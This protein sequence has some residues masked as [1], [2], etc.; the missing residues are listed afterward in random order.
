MAS[1]PDL[2]AE[3]AHIDRAYDSLERSRIEATRAALDGRGRQGRH[4]AGPLGAG[5]DRG[6]HR[7]A[8]GL[9]PAGRRQPGVRAH[10]PHPERGRATAS[11]SGAWP[12]PTSTASRWSSTGGPPWPSPSTG[13][14][15]ARRWAWSAAAT[16]PPGAAS[17]WPSRTSCSASRPGCSAASWP[18][19]D[20]GREIRGKSTLITA[21]EEVRTGPPHRHRR[22]DPGRA[23]RDH[24]GRP[25]RRAGRAGRPGHRQDGRGAAPRRLPALHAPLP[26]RGPGRAGGRARTGCSSATS[27]RCC[28]A[29][30]RPAWSWS[31]LADLLDGA[32]TL[33][34][35]GRDDQVAGPRQGRP[36]HGPRAGQ[37]RARPPAAACGPRCGSASACRPS[38]SARA[39]ATPS[40]PTPAAASASTTPAGAT[41]RPASTPP[42]PTAPAI[43]VEEHE[44]RGRLHATRRAARGPRPHVA[45]PHAGRAAP[46][47]VRLPGPDRPGRRATCSP[48]TERASLH[49]PRAERADDGGLDPRRRAAARRGPGAARAPAPQASP[50]ARPPTTRPAPTAT[51][52][53]TRP[54]TCRRCSC[55]CSTGARSTAR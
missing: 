29:S 13:P 15:G 14:P 16:S 27:S 23:G 24:P 42:S 4:G 54:R 49:R 34:I 20:D 52:W 39:R 53:W 45:G 46:R 25:A 19:V 12:W 50:R 37:G 2:S 36:A 17:S 9:P 11:T 47:P 5:D 55:A 38:P 44:V 26:A 31:V 40:W 8:A 41:S 30:A 48:T 33:H 10:R 3:Q 28:P 43:P 35:E 7:P 6:Q 32:G 22:H 21:L 18:I 1:H 51:S